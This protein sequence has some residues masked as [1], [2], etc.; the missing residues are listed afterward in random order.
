MRLT[1]EEL[2]RHRIPVRIVRA[3]DRLKAGDLEM[4]VL[5][6]PATGPEGNEN[7]RSLVLLIRHAGHSLLLTGDLEGAGLERVL[8]LALA[9]V[10]ILMAPHH[11]SRA[12]NTPRLADW[13]R[14][15]VVVSCE[16]PPRGSSRHAEP[17]TS[18]GAH[19]LGTWPHGAITI[20]SH[21]TGLVLETYRSGQ[22]LVVRQGGGNDPPLASR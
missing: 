9:N 5:H 16:G 11:G 6:P 22:R 15:R 17:Y 19:F 12:A 1:L 14:P 13:G 7:A 2:E 4:D 3:G 10:D 21:P 18:R 20:H 8:G